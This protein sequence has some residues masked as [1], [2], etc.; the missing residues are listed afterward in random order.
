MVAIPIMFSSYPYGTFNAL[1]RLAINL[2]IFSLQLSSF[3]LFAGLKLFGLVPPVV[4]YIVVVGAIGIAIHMHLQSGGKV[5]SSELSIFVDQLTPTTCGCFMWRDAAT[6]AQDLLVLNTRRCLEKATFRAV[7]AESTNTSK[8]S[9]HRQTQKVKIAAESLNNT[10]HAFQGETQCGLEIAT[11]LYSPTGRV[12]LQ[13]IVN[14]AI[15]CLVIPGLIGCTELAE[16]FKK[17]G[18]G[19][20][21]A[22]SSRSL[23][24][25]A[26]KIRT[27][28][29]EYELAEQK[30]ISKMEPSKPRQLALIVDETWNAGK[31]IL[32]AIDAITGFT[33]AELESAERT[34]E[35]WL[36]ALEAQLVRNVDFLSIVSD[37]ATALRSLAV[38]LDV[39]RFPDLFHIDQELSKCLSRELGRKVEKAKKDT[40]VATERREAVEMEKIQLENR[41]IKPVGRPPDW[42]KKHHEAKASERQAAKNLNSLEKYIK[43]VRKLKL[44]MNDYYHP[45]NPRTGALR[46]GS[47][48]VAGMKKQVE[49]IEAIGFKASICSTRLK[50][51]LGKAKR[52]I[53]RIEPAINRITEL[54]TQSLKQGGFTARQKKAIRQNIIPAIYLKSLCSMSRTT[55]KESQRLQAKAHNLLELGRKHFENKTSY[56]KA[57]DIAST[58]VNSFQRSSSPLEGLNGRLARANLAQ[59]SN[60][61]KAQ[62][63]A[64]IYRDYGKQNSLGK[65][66]AESFYGT[67][68]TS[69]CNHLA[70]IIPPF[71]E[72]HSVI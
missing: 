50:R 31:M 66:A 40:A 44:K 57:I 58:F 49:K 63:A 53:D 17:S 28:M 35:A 55:A 8:S 11:F 9:L 42:K 30:R 59:R 18:L 41:P 69:L 13:A 72:P 61:P 56:A 71:P 12:L 3:V 10:L 5:S 60:S 39:P 22:T 15:V 7:A 2:S 38:Q 67:P 65:C 24:R 16:F 27:E 25:Y 26:D 46:T 47:H 54:A 6:R 19:A 21:V 33:V 68:I 45:V 4:R 70:Q 62:A 36:K 1:L 52:A 43:S 23:N 48:I 34:T 32:V 64:R 37:E 14:A 51:H 29:L 20:A